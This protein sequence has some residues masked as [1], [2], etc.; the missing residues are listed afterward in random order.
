MKLHLPVTF[1][2]FFSKDMKLCIL[3]NDDHNILGA[4]TTM[5]Y[6]LNGINIYV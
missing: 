2:I 4:L 1:C 3:I 6:L 5:I